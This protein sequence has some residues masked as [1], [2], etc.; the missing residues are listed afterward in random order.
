MKIVNIIKKL[1]IYNNVIMMMYN[2]IKSSYIET[3]YAITM[4]LIDVIS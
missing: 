2:N 3:H 1:Y 4:M